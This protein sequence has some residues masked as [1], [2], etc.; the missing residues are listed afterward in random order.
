LTPPPSILDRIAEFGWFRRARTRRLVFLGLAIL[1]GLLT[2]FP[3]HYLAVVKL[4]PPETSTAGLS[5]VLGQLG[6]NYAALLA[7]HQ[8]AEINL[9]VARSF[10]VVRDVEKR[11][12]LAG[13]RPGYGSLNQT[14]VKLDRKV[15]VRVLRGGI[16]QIDVLDRDPVFAEQLVDT[17]ASALRNRLTT[18]SRAQVDY[19]RQVLNNRFAE[20]SQRLA[21][22]EAALTSFRRSNR[23]PA[24]EAQLGQAVSTL[25]GLEAEIQAKEVELQTALRFATPQNF[26]VKRIQSDISVLREQLRRARTQQTTQG[27]PTAA[28][29]A[30]TNT[31]YL[32][33]FRELRFSQ[34]LY[35][36]YTRYLEGSAIEDLT[37]EFNLQVI[38]SS[39]IDPAYHFNMVGLGL[40]LL[41]GLVAVG[42]EFYVTAPPVRGKVKLAA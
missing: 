37:A 27:L 23:L 7:S 13:N 4:V 2:L 36:S 31:R 22:A 17:Y 39:H 24:P 41:L 42:S 3:R 10:D 33:L 25:T 11:L 35:D 28:A 34:A 1:C 12:K 38:E 6:G 5:A 16:L 32:N 9:T 8:P 20:A 14:L 40:L 29:L 18:L 21:R 30:E 19:K 15:D 26:N